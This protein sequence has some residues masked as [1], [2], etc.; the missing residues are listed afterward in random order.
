MKTLSALLSLFLLPGIGLAQEPPADDPVL[1]IGG[2]LKALRAIE[3]EAQARLEAS[4]K[5]HE[6]IDHSLSAARIALARG[7][8]RLEDW[9]CYVDKL[10]VARAEQRA[11]ELEHRRSMLVEACSHAPA[12]CAAELRRIDLQIQ[13]MRD[14]A[15]KE[16]TSC[17]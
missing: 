15:K 5:T 16:M 4:A 11:L 12:D 6:R 1:M 10:V 7:E 14:A 2:D 3:R 9:P 13:I 8:Q 17:N